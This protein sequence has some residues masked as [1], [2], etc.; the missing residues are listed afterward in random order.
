MTGH[1][2]DNTIENYTTT[3]TNTGSSK[4]NW[5]K[6]TINNVGSSHSVITINKLYYFPYTEDIIRDLI[7]C[8][9]S[10]LDRSVTVRLIVVRKESLIYN[11]DCEMHLNKTN[12]TSEDV[13]FV[14]ASLQNFLTVKSFSE[15]RILCSQIDKALNEFMESVTLY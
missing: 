14:Y 15:D 11:L 9:N 10:T 12:V 3:Y 5:L 13:E 4:V 7:T 1:L 2:P 6:F 8:V